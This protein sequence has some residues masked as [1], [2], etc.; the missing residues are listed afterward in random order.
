MFN[1][2]ASAR[3]KRGALGVLLTLICLAG[4]AAVAFAQSVPEAQLP[5]VLG[6]RVSTT[7]ERARLI[8]DLS[9]N[10]EFAIVSLADPSR[11][12]VDVR[13]A[14]IAPDD[15]Q[16][17]AGTGVV[18]SFSVSMAEAGRA[19]AELVLNQPAVVQQAYVLDVVGDQPA[20]LVVDLI[21]TTAE[22]F[23]A[24]AAADL[25]NAIA[26]SDPEVDPESAQPDDGPA[27]DPASNEPSA[28]DVSSDA[29]KAVRRRARRP[30]GFF[31]SNRDRAEFF[32]GKCIRTDIVGATR[33]R[34]FACRQPAADRHRSRPWR[35]RQRRQ[36]TQW[37]PRKGHYARL[38]AAIA[39]PAGRSPASSTWR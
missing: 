29:P 16:T 21:P 9:G 11:I 15:K 32:R 8:I 17:V 5:Q 33:R 23:A 7:P 3:G 22:D 25:A 10:T 39:R 38:R 6:A 12:A 28:A 2:Q 13:A 18:T 27:L 20:R 37:H 24:R 4:S 19:R 30:S 31:R 26:R 36:C 1:S 35:H 14:S 34:C